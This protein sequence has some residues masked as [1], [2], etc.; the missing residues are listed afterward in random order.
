L[1]PPS[2]SYVELLEPALALEVDAEVAV[3]SPEVEGFPFEMP[4]GKEG[5]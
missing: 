3:G 1:R 5:P 2:N 4:F